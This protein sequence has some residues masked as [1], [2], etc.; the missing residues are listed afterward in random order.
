MLV[1][2]LTGKPVRTLTGLGGATG[3]AIGPHSPTMWVALADDHQLVEVDLETYEVVR[4]VPVPGQCPG[5]VASNGYH[6]VYGFS[7]MGYGPGGSGG[8]IGVFPV[9][10]P[11]PVPRVSTAGPIRRPLATSATSGSTAW[12]P[13]SP[14]TARNP[15]PPRA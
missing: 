15:A 10:D 6:V 3:L 14:G 13:R 9:A 8:G 11:E 7:C 4:R 1:T 12:S 5:D 2:D